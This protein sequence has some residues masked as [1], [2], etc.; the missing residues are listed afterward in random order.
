LE[1][2]TAEAG[3]AAGV[4]DRDAEEEVVSDGD[5]VEASPPSLRYHRPML[6]E[7]TS[8]IVSGITTAVGNRADNYI[9]IGFDMTMVLRETYLV[10]FVDMMIGIGYEIYRPISTPSR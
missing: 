8:G 9:L 3:R 4:K 6:W 1:Y 5:I 2:V 7:F 10:L